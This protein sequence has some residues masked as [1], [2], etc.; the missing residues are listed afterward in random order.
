VDESTSIDIVFLW[1]DGS[2]PRFAEL[3]RRHLPQHLSDLEPTDEL[4]GDTTRYFQMGEI[5]YAVRSVRHFA[6][7]IRTIYVVVADGQQPPPS[8]LEVPGVR[9]VRHSDIIPATCLPTF[10]SS[11]IEP[12]VH[13]IAGL[14]EVFIYGNDDFMFWNTTPISYFIDD[15]NLILRGGY[16]SRSLARIGARARRGHPKIASRT[17]LLLYDRGFEHVY[18]P[19]HAFEIFRKST[20]I[21]AWNELEQVMWKAVAAKFRDDDRALFWR[22]VVNTYEGH[23]HYPARVRSWNGCD[24]PFARVENSWIVAKYVEL[25]LTIIKRSRR[26]V[27]CFNTIPPTWHARMRRFFDVHYNRD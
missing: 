5:V 22:M 25:R 9:V 11:S 2:D 20:C 4:V 26:E 7:W 17:A 16:L 6:P 27:V 10:C 24:V 14:S 19:E 1:V 23:L 15:G 21:R 8:V 18:M 13:R 3:K 12:F